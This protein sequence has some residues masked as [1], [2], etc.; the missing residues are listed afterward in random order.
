M[1]RILVTILL[2]VFLVLPG[3]V[4]AQ[5]LNQAGGKLKKLGDASGTSDVGSLE[6]VIG[7]GISAALSLVGMIFLILMVYAGYLW[8]TARGD[9]PQIEKARKII[10]ASVIGL[11]IVM[12]AYAITFLITKRFEGL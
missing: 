4:S 10:I 5:N 12:S 2:A 11:M 7:R 1:K 3:I 6:V 9:E 8:M